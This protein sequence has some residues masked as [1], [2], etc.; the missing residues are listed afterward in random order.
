MLTPEDVMSV[1]G[2]YA[3]QDM[4]EFEMYLMAQSRETPWPICPRGTKRRPEAEKPHNTLIESS[5]AK[6]LIFRGFVEATSNRTFI[7][8]E[9]GYQFYEREMKPHFRPAH[10]GTGS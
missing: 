2:Q 3:L 4:V 6:E 1:G 8:S 5:I 9:S 7:V 10:H